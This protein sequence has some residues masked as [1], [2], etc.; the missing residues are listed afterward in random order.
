MIED[1]LE[2]ATVEINGNSDRKP[3]SCKEVK[4][5]CLIR[6]PRVNLHL[7]YSF[8]EKNEILSSLPLTSIAFFNTN[9]KNLF[10]THTHAHT[11]AYTHTRIHHLP[12]PFT[13]SSLK[14]PSSTH[15]SPSFIV[16]PAIAARNFRFLQL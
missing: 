3:I 12:L 10:R 1:V 8:V 15:H 14:I 16:F 5:N 6:K 9:I 2:N 4:L 7:S 13:F 11:H